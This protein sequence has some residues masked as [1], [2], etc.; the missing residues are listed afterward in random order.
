MNIT[1]L[2]LSLN[3]FSPKEPALSY[4]H[5]VSFQSISAIDT[6]NPEGVYD[7]AKMKI[8]V[9]A[10]MDLIAVQWKGLNKTDRDAM[11][12]DENG[13][14]IQKTVLYTGASIAYFDTQTMY[15]G[16][17]IIKFSDGKEWIPQKIKL[18]K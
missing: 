9:N 15:A 6:L 13:K 12:I 5:S 16:N 4:S 2:L 3:I 18:I 17:Y 14:T 7:L 1:L 10:K 8:L 11:I